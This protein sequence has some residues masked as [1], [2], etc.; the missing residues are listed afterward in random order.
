MEKFERTFLIDVDPARGTVVSLLE[1]K[2]GCNRDRSANEEDGFPSLSVDSAPPTF[3]YR[4]PWGE[5]GGIFSWTLASVRPRVVERAKGCEAN[6][7]ILNPTN[8]SDTRRAYSWSFVTSL[9]T[10][11]RMRLSTVVELLLILLLVAFA[12]YGRVIDQDE[13]GQRAI[14]AAADAKQNNVGLSTMSLK[15]ATDNVNKFCTCNENIC[16]CCREFHIP[17]VQLNGPGCASL[18]YLQEDNLAVQLSFGDNILTSTI[19]QGKSP[20]PVCVPLPGG[21]S[22][23]CGRIYSIQ[24]DTKNHF[25][26]CLGLELQ[27]ASELEASLRVS[28]FRFGPDGLQ[29]RPAEP[30]PIVEAETSSDDSDDDDL[31]GLGSDEDDEDDEDSEENDGYTPLANAAPGSSNAE[32]TEEDEDEDDDDED[33]LGFGALLDIFTGEDE[34]TTKKPKVTTAAPLLHFTIPIL[35]PTTATPPAQNEP[36]LVNDLSSG[37]EDEGTED[38]YTQEPEDD[39]AYATESA[40]EDLSTNSPTT[41][42]ENAQGSN[43]IAYVAKPPS[44]KLKKVTVPAKKKPSVSSNN[45]NLITDDTKKQKRPSKPVKQEEEEEEDDI[46]GDLEDDDDEEDELDDG[47]EEEEQEEEEEDE[48]DDEGDDEHHKKHEHQSDDEDEKAED[49]EDLDEDDDDDDEEEDEMI[50]AL[51]YGE[52]GDGKKK[53]KKKVKK[54]QAVQDDDS[55]YGLGLTG[56]L[57]R[58]RSIRQSDRQSR[59]MRL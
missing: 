21:F 57:A 24:R 14:R 16:N 43:K 50:S 2:S 58:R 39:D 9:R 33:V 4:K 47:E 6:R 34:T 30:L 42:D 8:L 26:A 28:C 5:L 3:S 11:E 56:L 27:S 23:F 41:E 48:D 10:A 31:F 38:D 22:R 12:A 13:T 37:L 44:N 40:T 17:L 53:K 52:K 55:D 45:V 54:S 18:Q 49:L 46:L 15:Q 19:V 1:V 35:K 20:K 32:E 7:V 29:L 25:K 51:V 59:I 36:P